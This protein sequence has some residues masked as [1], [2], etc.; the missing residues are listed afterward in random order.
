MVMASPDPAKPAGLAAVGARSASTRYSDPAQSP[1]EP[2]LMTR[3]DCKLVVRAGFFLA[4]AGAVVL[5]LSGCGDDGGSVGPDSASEDVTEGD[6]GT[7]GDDGDVTATTDA[8]GPDTGEDEDATGCDH[9]CL[10]EFGQNDK[11]LCPTPA[12]EWN[13]VD[14]CCEA[15]F[16][17][18]SNEDCAANGFEEGQCT[19]ESLGCLCDAASGTCFSAFCGVDADCAAGTLCAA[20]S[21]LPAPPTASLQLRIISRAAVLTPGATAQVLVE[22]WDA[23]SDHGDLVDGVDVTWSSDADPVVAIS[24]EG[25]VT[26]GDTAGEATITATATDGGATAILTMRNVV[27]AA[28]ATLTV[29]AV[30]EG[31]LAPVTGSYALVDTEGATV[32]TGD[33]AEGGLI[34]YDGA[35]GDGLDVHIFGDTTDWVSWLGAGEGVLYLPLGRSFWGEV[36]LN[37]EAEVVE[38]ETELIGANILT[39]S[40]D[41]ADYEKLGEL[42]M[43]VTSFQFSSALFDFN[44]ESIIGSNV[45]RF[46]DPEVAIPGLDDS[47]VAEI[48]GGLTFFV[49]GPAI[50]QYFLSAPKGQHRIWTLG[51]R[52]AIDEIAEYIDEVFGAFGGG[53]VNFGQLVGFLV[54]FFKDFWTTV[55]ITPEFAGDGAPTVETLSPRLRVPMR[56]QTAVTIP[57]LPTLGDWGHADSLFLIAGAL[58]ADSF[59]V[60]LGLGAGSD[61]EDAALDPPDGIVDGDT[62]TPE[63]DPLVVPFAPLHSGLGGPHTALSF[64]TV[65]VAIDSGGDKTRPEGGSAIFHR[66]AEGQPM[67]LALEPDAFLP[68]PMGSSWSA[69]TRELA[70]E[71]VTGADTQ[72]V[73][74]KGKRGD[75]WT[76][77]LNGRSDYVVPVPA[78][79]MGDAEL[80]DRTHE[81]SLVLVGS[82]DLADGVTAAQLG[83]PGGRSLDQ[84]LHVVDRTC[85]LDLWFGGKGLQGGPD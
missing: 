14:G 13:C 53:G 62:T 61:T 59:F 82:F 22:A 84:L 71:G 5:T 77:W 56:L 70:V 48:P 44:L 66:Q 55:D 69:D 75:N 38:D 25:V 41:L 76:V 33:V 73:L 39:G 32:A 54:P 21:C 46:F 9:P 83:M 2:I 85:F 11:K 7:G 18:S 17:C 60:P 67:D 16:H 23:D 81:P 74:F 30:E 58:T 64:A 27:P 1:G 15:V 36:V 78:D 20:G 3:V 37:E 35:V 65:A 19:D 79:L 12:S 28:S 8:G 40:V 4:L 51:G 6:S 50:P 57:P 29:I 26:G 49:A 24:A 68:F 43:T 52:I 47:S 63:P 72:R 10:N 80:A 42:D 34:S 31:S 45:K